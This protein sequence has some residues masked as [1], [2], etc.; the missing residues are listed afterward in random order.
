MGRAKNRKPPSCS[1][2]AESPVNEKNVILELLQ[3]YLSLLPELKG[4][5]TTKQKALHSALYHAGSKAAEALETYLKEKP[6]LSTRDRTV[7]IIYFVLIFRVFG[8]NYFLLQS[9]G[10]ELRLLLNYLNY[11]SIELAADELKRAC[12]NENGQVLLRDQQNRILNEVAAVALSAFTYA[13]ARRP[14]TK[15]V[16]YLMNPT[17]SVEVPEDNGSQTSTAISND[18]KGSCPS[19]SVKSTFSN[20]FSKARK[21]PNRRLK[22]EEEEE[23]EDDDEDD[24][25]EEDDDET[26]SAYAE[27]SDVEDSEEDDLDQDEDFDRTDALLRFACT[28]GYGDI[29]KHITKI[30]GSAEYSHIKKTTI[31]ME[32]CCS[33]HTDIVKDLLEA[34]ADV[35]AVSPSQNTPL[36]YAATAGKLDVSLYFIEGFKLF[37]SVS[38]S[39][40]NTLKLL[41]MLATSLVILL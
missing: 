25:E 6:M 23:D 41:W 39:Y 22:S 3:P 30:R 26:C 29:V 33:G 24:D 32:A 20:P 37:F 38:E 34:G 27:D 2:S 5:G 7:S 4:I 10:Q 8:I 1:K 13:A 9:E 18:P 21:R 11:V 31:L 12:T 28:L 19:G 16:E 36:I 15:H 17:A 14:S 35:N 40:L